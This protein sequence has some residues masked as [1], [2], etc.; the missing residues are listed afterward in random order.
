MVFWD[1]GICRFL[2]PLPFPAVHAGLPGGIRFHPLPQSR[3]LG[4]ELETD[5]QPPLY[6]LDR[7]A[8]VR[9]GLNSLVLNGMSDGSRFPVDSTFR[10]LPIRNPSGWVSLLFVYAV[11]YTSEVAAMYWIGWRATGDNEHVWYTAPFLIG[12]V[13]IL[14]FWCGP[15]AVYGK[16]CSGETGG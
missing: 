4:L 14:F 1:P 6:L 7:V 13:F 16:G 15:I 10:Q 3:I 2:G 5:I 9:R 11:G 12:C 8:R